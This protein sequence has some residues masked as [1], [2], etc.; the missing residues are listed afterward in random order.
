[1]NYFFDPCDLYMTFKVKQSITF[2]ATYPLMLLTKFRQNPI[3]H[4]GG[5]A[6]SVKMTF[7]TP[8][9]LT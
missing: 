9:T 7:L 5:D 4:V 2:V 6:F 3:K 1:M 8:V